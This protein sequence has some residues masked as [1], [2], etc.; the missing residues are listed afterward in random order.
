MSERAIAWHRAGQIV[1]RGF[2]QYRRRAGQ[3]AREFAQHR[4]GQHMVLLDVAPSSVKWQFAW[5]RYEDWISLKRGSF[6][7]NKSK[8]WWVLSAVCLLRQLT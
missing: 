4:A 5:R 7:M 1:E 8:T 6:G 3:L 2:V